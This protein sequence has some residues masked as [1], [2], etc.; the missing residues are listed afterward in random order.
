MPRLSVAERVAKITTPDYERFRSNGRQPLNI[1]RLFVETPTTA[2]ID[3]VVSRASKGPAGMHGFVFGESMVGKSAALLRH[4][5][6]PSD[7]D[8]V[9]TGPGILLHAENL[10]T[11]RALAIGLCQAI[12]PGKVDVLGISTETATQAALGLLA[13]HDGI[14]VIDDIQEILVHGQPRPGMDAQLE[15]LAQ[16]GRIVVSGRSIGVGRC[17]QVLRTFRSASAEAVEMVGLTG[18]PHLVDVLAGMEL[19]LGLGGRAYLAGATEAEWLSG[20]VPGGQPG[21]FKQILI[22][23]GRNACER[24]LDRL[25]EAS[26]DQG[27]KDARETLSVVRGMVLG[28]IR[29]KR[30]LGPGPVDVRFKDTLVSAVEEHSLL[31]PPR[32]R[33]APRNGILKVAIDASLPIPVIQAGDLE[34]VATV[35]YGFT[36][37]RREDLI[38]RHR[39][40]GTLYVVE[41]PDTDASTHVRDEVL[42]AADDLIGWC[43]EPL[44]LR[45][46][47]WDRLTP[48][49]ARERIAENVTGRLPRLASPYRIV[50]DG[51]VAEQVQP[52]RWFVAACH[53]GSLVGIET[54]LHALEGLA[55]AFDHDEL[56]HARA[57]ADILDKRNGREIDRGRVPRP[58][59]VREHVEG[60]LPRDALQRFLASLSAKIRSSLDDV[61]YPDGLRTALDAMASIP[62]ER[63]RIDHARVLDAINIVRDGLKSLGIRAPGDYD[64]PYSLLDMALIKVALPLGRALDPVAGTA[65][66]APSRG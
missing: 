53:G 28:P 52:P 3:L 4:A 60:G 32:G 5:R 20:K 63:A 16:V 41:A 7:K 34:A 12:A 56:E 10:T 66:Q 23:A 46:I 42:G 2:A 29:R 6:D 19:G 25:D 58:Q 24:G 17:L 21:A 30:S 59:S 57:F 40:D 45:N 8:G 64:S 31:D 65:Y 35:S 26:L 50:S 37:F 54:E 61:V 43:D 44:A 48:Q 22:H 51:R 9:V 33:G 47:P 55:R 49:E 18:Q 13:M 39:P 1:D 38:H 15:K 11:P 14:L 62:A 36:G 27:L